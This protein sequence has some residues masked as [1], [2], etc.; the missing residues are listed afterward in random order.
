MRRPRFSRWIRLQVLSLAHT[1]AFSLRSLAAQAQREANGEL[2]AAL[3]LYAHENQCVSRL[4]S[5]VYDEAL[6]REFEKVEAHLGKRSAER[7]ALRGTPM[8]SLPEKYRA[9]LE[10]YERAYHT[11]ERIAAEKLALQ[12]QAHEAVLRSGVSPAA[13]A[14]TLGVDPANLHAY[15]TRGETHRINLEAAHRLVEAAS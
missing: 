7:L 5:Y 9:L 8:R 1:K 14:R 6:Q 4:M 11:P 15:I 12:R 10:A 3:L 13:L 2:A